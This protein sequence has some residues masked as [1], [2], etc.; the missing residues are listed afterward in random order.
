MAPQTL[1]PNT[2][3]RWKSA[4]STHRITPNVYCTHLWDTE[5]SLVCVD[6]VKNTRIPFQR[7]LNRAA[8]RLQSIL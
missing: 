3:W 6:F 1:N 2:R 7:F 4:Y 5:W 8:I